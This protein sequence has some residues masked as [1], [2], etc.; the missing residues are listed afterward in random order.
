M[1]YKHDNPGVLI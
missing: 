1:I